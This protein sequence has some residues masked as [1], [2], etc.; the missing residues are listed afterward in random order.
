MA[1]VL[2]LWPAKAD[3]RIGSA[4]AS[5]LAALGVTSLALMRD[6]EFVG[7]VLDGWAFDPTRSARAAAAVLGAEPQ[8]RI[9]F[10]LLEI[11]VTNAT[12]IGGSDDSTLAPAGGDAGGTQPVGG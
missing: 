5:Q 2:M 11:G 7:V 12:A 10:P 9:L 4:Q 8:C 3:L 6:R 1:K